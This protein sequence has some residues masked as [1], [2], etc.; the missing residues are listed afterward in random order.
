MAAD[1][2]PAPR[3]IAGVEPAQEVLYK[4]GTRVLEMECREQPERLRQLLTAYASDSAIVAELNEFR[5]LASK[6]GPVVFIGM[7]AS[8]C[9]S[10][11][12]SVLL[13]T[14]GRLSFSVDAGEWLNYASSVWDDAALSIL[15]TTSG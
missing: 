14:N 5:E 15:L 10:F 11:G 3:W 7:G 9:S 2:Q 8:Y 6:K 4:T 12:G 13:E 1:K